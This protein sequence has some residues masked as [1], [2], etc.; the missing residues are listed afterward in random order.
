M[1]PTKLIMMGVTFLVVV[2]LGLGSFFV[3]PEGHVGVVKRFSKAQYQQGP[4]IHFKLPMIE[5]VE[6]FEVRQRKNVEELS[7]ATA[8]QLPITAIVSINWTVN[9]DSAM[10]IFVK[11]GGLIQFEQRILD[12]KLRQVA[13]A[14]LSKFR[15][16]ELIRDRNKAVALIQSG[17]ISAMAGYPITVNSPQIENIILPKQYLAAI[18][19]KEKAR[20]EAKTE[21]HKLEKQRMISLQSVN[22]AEAE[23]QAAVKRAD[24]VAY[25]IE[26]EARAQALAVTMAGV[27]EA[28]AVSAVN[29]ALA[30]NPLLVEY[31]KAKRWD[32]AV[33]RMLLG[34][35]GTNFLMDIG[36][37]Q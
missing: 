5:G 17:M 18:M 26:V 31:Q 6:K 15:A 32:G 13:K 33:P 3:V 25:A 24:G 10:E 36:K 20:E 19:E 14:S 2:M 37:V 4:G 7:A 29:K 34:G 11:Y 12:P 8:N 21:E 16:D 27:A 28:S 1:N 30:G 23:R 22:T 9:A 35:G